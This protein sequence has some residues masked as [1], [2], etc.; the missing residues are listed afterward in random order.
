MSISNAH[1]SYAL[2]SSTNATLKAVRDHLQSAQAVVD[3]TQANI[4][5][6]KVRDDDNTELCIK[7]INDAGLSLWVALKSINEY[8]GK[9]LRLLDDLAVS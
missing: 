9:V 2:L 1:P 4:K 5:H 6:K 8:R 3:A 7:A